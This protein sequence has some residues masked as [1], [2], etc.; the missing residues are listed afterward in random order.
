MLIES[1]LDPEMCRRLIESPEEAFQGFDLTDEEKDL[2]RRP[3]HRLLRLL[4]IAL[5][6]EAESSPGP[7]ASTC[8]TQ[9]HAI[10]EVRS[11]PDLSLLLTLVPCAQYENGQLHTFAYA[12][13]VSPLPPGADP[14]T[15]PPP[16]GVAFPG[17]PLTPQPC[18]PVR[19]G[20]TPAVHRDLP[21]STPF[22][23]GSSRPRHDAL[24]D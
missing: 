23:R 15:L 5:A 14:A 9:P 3:D 7:K 24:A 13:W 19:G 21:A 17:R 18:G 10:A 16:P 22:G 6:E 2:L 8:V 1:A 4:G 12:V 11:L 20:S